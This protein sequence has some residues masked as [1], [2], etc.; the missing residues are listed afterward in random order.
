MAAERTFP[1]FRPPHPGEYLRQDILPAL[2]MT[3]TEL[4]DHLGV[5]R[6]TLSDLI[7]EKR[8]VSVEMAQRLGQAFKNGTRFWL[9]LQMQRDIWEAEQDSGIVV[10]PIRRKSRAA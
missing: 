2:G 4:A 5:S 1:K 10:K 9:A 7:H 8:A 6:P 3:V